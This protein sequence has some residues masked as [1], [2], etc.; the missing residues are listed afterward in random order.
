MIRPHL[1]S[2]CSYGGQR[3]R[4]DIHPDA[5]RFRCR[6]HHPARS[7]RFLAALVWARLVE[8]NTY[9]KKMIWILLEALSSNCL[10]NNTQKSCFNLLHV[11]V[12]RRQ[13]TYVD[14]PSCLQMTRAAFRSTPSSQTVP[15]RPLYITSTRP[16]EGPSP[17][18]RRIPDKPPTIGWVHWFLVMCNR[19][20][21]WYSFFKSVNTGM[22]KR[23]FSGGKCVTV[24]G[25]AR[26]R[27]R[28]FVEK[29]FCLIF[30]Q[31]SFRE[32]SHFC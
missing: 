8:N 21:K 14:R 29:E 24:D 17:A 25:I 20:W 10:S 9:S 12:T 19:K 27:L 23:Q 4:A 32:I 11:C 13:K 22:R 28:H 1:Q 26:L 3:A 31:I 6:R 15:Q 18:T 2:V 7:D 30:I 5:T 16:L